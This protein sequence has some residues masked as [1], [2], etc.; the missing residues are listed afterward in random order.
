MASDY[1]RS[2]SSKKP[3]RPEDHSPPAE[4]ISLE[5]LEQIERAKQEW[6]ATVDALPQ[7][8]CLLNYQ[9][10]IIRANR[11]VEHWGLGQVS[12]VRGQTA[13]DLLAPVY[14]EMAN[15]LDDFLQSA[16]EGLAQGRA[17][18]REV[19]GCLPKRYW[20]VQLQPI[21]T[22][23]GRRTK[24]ASSFAALV[25]HDITERKLSEQLKNEFLANMSEELQTPLTAIIGY[26]EIMLLGLD[27]ELPARAHEDVQA[28]LENGQHLLHLITE[29]LDLAKLQ[30]GSVR[31][32]PERFAISPLF[33]ELKSHYSPLVSQKSIKFSVEVEPH[34]PNLQ[35]DKARLRQILAHLIAN[36]VKFT[37]TGHIH[38]RAFQEANR[39]CF[40]VEDTGIGMN[41]SDLE[42]IFEHFRQIDGSLTRQAK[43]AGL[44]LAITQH[45]VHMHQ[46]AIDVQSQVGRGTIVTVRL[47][48]EP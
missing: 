43:G 27:G 2:K 3:V 45:L 13:H 36:A 26:S 9:G 18:E 41:E 28:I 5:T 24:A 21:P 44:G 20:H 12:K 16:W 10:H 38:L 35:A 30:A 48:I 33:E 15:H 8:V 4:Q 34:L 11:A 39:L 7:L 6:E 42:T 22:Q 47:P 14:Q 37:E 23:I 32:K 25:I 31:L 40:Q 17:S 1:K 46:G 19:E 29:I